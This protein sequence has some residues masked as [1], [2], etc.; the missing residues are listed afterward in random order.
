[1][2][3]RL[4]NLATC[5]GFLGAAAA[6]AVSAR[7][8]V[9]PEAPQPLAWGALPADTSLIA[10]LDVKRARESPLWQSLVSAESPLS[11]VG[12]V[13]RIC[14]EE[15]ARQIETIALAIPPHPRGSPAE[16]LPDLGLSITG[17]FSAASVT[18]CA[19]AVIAM[20]DGEAVTTPLAGS[21]VSLHDRTRARAG[22]LAI[23]DGMALL[24]S[25]ES[26][27]RMIATAEGREPSVAS[28]ERHATLRRSLGGPTTLGITWVPDHGWLEEWLGSP[29]ARLSPFSRVERF[30]LRVDGVPDLRL[31]AVLECASAEDCSRVQGE[32]LRLAQRHLPT[33]T[34]AIGF[35]LARRASLALEGSRVSLQLSLRVDEARSLGEFLLPW[36]LGQ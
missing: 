18:R 3:V 1:M 14:A 16:P 15:A 28:N 13:P 20:R 7:S 31:R 5:F 8:P 23:R 33:L 11:Q 27:E 29:L 25:A 2:R 34:E 6:V 36:L 26:L 21:F 9:E 4:A 22:E 12:G 32:V 10:T 35:D 19:T 30:A 17:S 24:G